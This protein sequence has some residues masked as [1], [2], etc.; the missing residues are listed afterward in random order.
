MNTMSAAP[1]A[2]ASSEEEHGLCASCHARLRGRYCHHC[3]ERALREH[4]FTLAH[5]IEEALE[6]ISH[7]DGKIIATF[8]ALLLRPGLL[9]LEYFRGRRQVYMR[10][11]AVFLV[12]NLAFL[13]FR[14]AG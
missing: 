12:A 6:A 14:S 2:S 13:S 5:Y 8:R 7:L 4:D 1:P 9:T 11:F 3:G 10:P